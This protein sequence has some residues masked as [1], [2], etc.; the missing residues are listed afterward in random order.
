MKNFRS[1]IMMKYEQF[2][3]RCFD[4]V[5]ELLSKTRSDWYP[6]YVIVG[7]RINELENN[8]YELEDKIYELEEE[9]MQLRTELSDAE[10][11]VSHMELYK[12]ECGEE[13]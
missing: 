4:R 2:L 7:D 6:E 1:Y 8:I 9:N 3:M 12:F 11:K 5:C 10:E 13:A